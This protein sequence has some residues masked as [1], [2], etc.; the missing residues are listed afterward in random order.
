[1]NHDII[2][3]IAIR[4]EF[5]TLLSL[6]RA[7]IRGIDAGFEQAYW[8][9][10]L[11]DLQIDPKDDLG[12]IVRLLINKVK[13]VDG[14]DK[15]MQDALI[16]AVFKFV[17]SSCNVN[18]TDVDRGATLLQILCRYPEQIFTRSVKELIRHPE[19]RDLPAND[20]YTAVR[21]TCEQDDFE[22]LE[23][24]VLDGRFMPGR[25][26]LYAACL[27]GRIAMVRRLL[28]MPM[29]PFDA[30]LEA[31]SIGG[32]HDI[33]RVLASKGID[34]NPKQN[35]PS[36]MSLAFARGH[37]EVVLELLR[38]GACKKR[39]LHTAAFRNNL[40]IVSLLFDEFGVDA[41]AQ[42]SKGRTA[43]HI[44]CIYGHHEM[45]SRLLENKTTR[46][47]LPCHAGLTPLHNAC[48][49]EYPEAALRVLER[50]DKNRANA[51]DCT[52]LT[53]LYYAIS[54]KNRVLVS[55]LLCRG[56]GKIDIEMTVHGQTPLAQA[57]RL[58]SVDVVRSLLDA[59]ADMNNTSRGETALHVA[60]INDKADIVYELVN[61]PHIQSNVSSLVSGDTPLMAA[62]RLNNVGA[63]RA[64]RSAR[65]IDVNATNL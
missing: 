39:A 31:A 3:Q 10:R 35:K 49:S 30:C 64:L 1:M 2:Q 50:L 21:V 36:A 44:A 6:A 53:P 40:E 17:R 15:K 14:S 28:D 34:L 37:S 45:V 60:C 57:C 61:H 29:K 65:D 51:R 43:L 20:T 54:S 27:Q 58:S 32:Y 16:M 59:G 4:C 55:R 22:K 23:L 11:V 62:C 9:D 42:D 26:E 33:V 46:P 13:Y 24:F 41:N 47:D 5:D 7:P 52:G 19:L 18:A 25:K 48:G 12:S 38:L 8:E 63:V 56:I